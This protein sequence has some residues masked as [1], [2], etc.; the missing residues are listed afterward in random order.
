MSWEQ[1]RDIARE[2]ADEA[3]DE[4]ARRPEACPLDGTVLEEG[5]GGVLFCR[6]DGWQYPRD[7]TPPPA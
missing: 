4:R 3:R 6:A 2:A 7:W 1:L 5:P